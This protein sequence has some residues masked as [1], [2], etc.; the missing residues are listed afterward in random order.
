AGVANTAFKF[1]DVNS[2]GTSFASAYLLE[3]TNG[4]TLVV[5][6][7]VFVSSFAVSGSSATLLVD[8]GS[9]AGFSADYNDYFSSNAA[10]SFQWAANS[11]QG[12]L[13]WRSASGQDA[14]ALSANPLWAGTAAGSEDFHPLSIGGRWNQAAQARSV[15]D[16]AQSATIS[17]GDPAEVAAGAA[18][19]DP[20]SVV[21]NQG[22]YGGTPQASLSFS[23]AGCAMARLV[24]AGQTYATISTALGTLPSSLPPGK[25]CVVV[26]DGATYSEAVTVQN[27]TLN[28][29][30]IAIFADPATHLTPVVSPPAGTA[31]FVVANASVSVAGID[32]V[33]ANAI[34]YGIFVSSTYVTISSVNIQDA[35]GLISAAGMALSSWTSVSDSSVTVGGSNASG[36]WLPGSAMTNISYCS[37]S[38]NGVG[39]ASALWLDAASSNTIT[40]VFAGNAGGYGAYAY[41]D[42][43]GNTIALS[44]MTGGVGYAALAVGLSYG[45][46]VQQSYMSDTGNVGA[47]LFASSFNTI[48]RSTMTSGGGGGYGLELSGASSNTITLSEMSD[49][50]GYGAFVTG[51]Q[52]NTI[53]GSTMTSAAA[54]YPALYLLQTASNTLSGD[55]VEGSTAAWVSGSTGTV[56]GAN[57]LVAT[58]LTGSALQMDG[59]SVNLTLSSSTLTAQ[60]GGAAVYLGAGDGGEIIL[61]TNVIS[62]AQYGVY[63]ATPAASAQLWIGSNTIVPSLTAGNNTYA[64]YFDG[65]ASGATIE[66]NTVAYRAPGSMGG[67]TSYALYAQSASGLFIDHNR[68]DEPGMIS[69]GSFEALAFAATT[70]STVTYNDVFSSG[71]GLTNFYLLQ[72]SGGST[73]LVVRNNIFASSV[74]VIAVTG[75]S[76]TVAVDAASAT[77]FYANYNDYFSSNTLGFEYGGS[78]YATLAAWQAGAVQD[79]GSISANPLW[80][81]TVAGA[82]DFHPL[83]QSGRWTP[84]GIVADGGTS[85][86]VDAGDPADGYGNEPAPNGGRVNQGS[87]GGTAQASE[88]YIRPNFAGCVLTRWVGAGQPFRTITA[89]LDSI[90]PIL[91]PGESCVVIEDGAAYAEQVTVQKFSMHLSSIAIFADPTLGLTPVVTPPALSTAAFVIANASVSVMGIDV[92]A[93]DAMPYGILISSTYVQISSVNVSDAGANIAAAGILLSSWTEVNATTVTV[94]GANAAGFLLPP[95]SAMSSVSYSSASVSSPTGYALWLDGSSSNTFTAVYAGNPAGDAACLTAGADANT[96]SGSTMTSAAVG[97]YGLYVQQASSNTFSGDYIRGST[98]AYISDST[99]TVI[100]G[101]V[102]V[103]TNTAGS[104]LQM[105]SG[106]V[107]LT[108]SSSA[109]TGG[110]GGAAVYLTAD[111]GLVVLSTNTFFGGR[112]GLYAGNFA[113][114]SQIWV[115]SNTIEPAVS[116]ASGTYGLFLGALPSGATVEN[117][118]VVYR[119]PGSMGAFTSYAL[120]A[121]NSSGLQIDHNR[122][123]EPGMIKSGSYVAVEFTGTTRSAFKFNDVYSTGTG[124]ASAYLL[125][126]TS[127][128]TG[129]VVKDNVFMSSFAFAA[130]GSSGTILVDATSGASFQADYN[131]YFSSNA[132]LT[133][134]WGAVAVRG[135]AAWQ[136]ATR[137]DAHAISV[138][139][140]WE[141]PASGIEDFHPLSPA[142]RW[143]PATQGFVIVDTGYSAAIDAGDPSE[144]FALEPAPNGGVANLG[145]YGDTAQASRSEPAP[146]AVAIVAVARRASRSRSARSARTPISFRPRRPRASRASSTPR[147]RPPAPRSSRPRD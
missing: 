138:N 1:N 57:V 61:S 19:S 31:A 83:S 92:L 85:A 120:L 77:G 114:R 72:A 11:A 122:F 16:G 115:T 54:G 80:E 87:Y 125:E 94:G 93:A 75:S 41:P 141:N 69:A 2:T 103:A 119:T 18:Q 124:F 10:L 101:S 52:G 23:F 39:S 99:G 14:H 104:A 26:E 58:S 137:G 38:A 46:A 105:D 4:S 63:A 68:I 136:S 70:N 96:F 82:E 40:A 9:E 91:S 34:L 84:A 5:K 106:S 22:S 95:G 86:T 116:A 13:G 35:G 126:A 66:N 53:S 109:L 51:G 30:S 62:G 107:N 110:P 142:G 73:G 98:A 37:A 90:P 97:Y 50:A 117:N 74:T 6:D 45:N 25:I 17:A 29:S 65:L 112:F 81:S 100:G 144:P 123:D 127:G 59:G 12:T 60:S 146:S 134:Q 24:G 89:A 43:N 129:L 3:A 44:T 102:L 118:T 28:A 76:Q 79:A 49:T 130:N 140:L 145:S 15:H 135:L 55:Y 47:Y 56:I 133:F 78:E 7:N 27:F 113:P 48:S 108:L 36:F 139:P 20:N 33:P 147:S 8:A 132:F 21:A 42:S 64:L 88:S 32:I 131:D 121:Q 143:S 128:S 111:G 71:T 67:F